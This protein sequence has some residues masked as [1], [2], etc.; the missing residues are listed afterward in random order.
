[1][2]I[3]IG[4]TF[5]SSPSFKKTEASVSPHTLTRGKQ[6]SEQMEIMF[7]LA[8]NNLPDFSKPHFLLLHL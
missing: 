7:F 3:W 1:M 8:K 4:L 6:S 2:K 5:N